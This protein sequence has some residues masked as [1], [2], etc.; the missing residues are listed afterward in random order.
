MKRMIMLAVLCAF[1]LSAAAAS[2]ADI[3]ASGAWAVEAIWQSNWGFNDN[4]A[5]NAEAKNDNFEVSQRARTIFDFVANENLKAVLYTAYGTQEW[6]QGALAI[7]AGDGNSA[8]TGGTRNTIQVKQAYIDFNYP[9]T[10]VHVRVGYQ[11]VALP[12]AIGGGSYILDEEAAA[13]VVSGPITDNVSYLV[14]YTRAQESANEEHKGYI[15]AYVAALPMSFDGFTF[16]PFGMYAPIGSGVKAADTP[17]GLRAINATDGTGDSFDNAYWLGAAFTMDLFDPF[18]VK[19]DLNY[20]KVAS[21]I[22]ANERSGWL[23]DAAVE[24]KGFDF[25]TPE[26]T[27]VYTSGEDGNGSNDL[28]SERMPVLAASNWAIGSFFFGGDTLLDGTLADRNEYMGFWALALSLKD[29]QSFTEGL[30]HTAHIVYAQGTND[31]NINDTGI[32][33]NSWDYGNSLTEKDSLWEV[34]FNTAY[35]LY[36]ELTMTLD[37]GYVNLD[38]DEAVWGAD[39]KGGDAWKVSTG[40]VYKF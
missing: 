34:D 30:T 9:D 11:G 25:M 8:T 2:A 17:D 13:A 3:K 39:Y 16:Q 24:Y 38:A 40:I 33:G 15:D 5:T 26:L 35:K 32:S 29:I 28:S 21:D 4:G 12:A 20:G 27:F 31:K 23:F 36:D 6:G 22:E 37:L 7:G 14:G 19:A 18:V 10:D 1:V